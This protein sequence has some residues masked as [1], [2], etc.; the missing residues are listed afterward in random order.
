[1]IAHESKIAMAKVQLGVR[2]DAALKKTLSKI[3]K[4]ERRPLNTQ[5]EIIIED[6]LAARQKKPK[7]SAP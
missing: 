2:I 5:L 7:R 3:A 4:E 6:W 1:M